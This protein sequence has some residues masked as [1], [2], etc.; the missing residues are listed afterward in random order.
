MKKVPSYNTRAYRFKKW[1]MK[2]WVLYKRRHERHQTGFM[3]KALE[4]HYYRPAFYRFVAA[5]VTNPHIL[6]EADINADSIV[7]DIGAYTGDWAKHLLDRYNPTVYAFEPNPN[8]FQVLERKKKHYPKLNPHPYGLGSRNEI[9]PMSMADLGSSFFEHDE[10]SPDTPW[11]EAEIKSVRDVWKALDFQDVDLVKINIEGAE[12][13]LLEQMIDSDL[14]SS[15]RIFMIQFHEWH[16][17][18]YKRRRRIRRALRKTHKLDWDYHFV[19][20]KW[21]RR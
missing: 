15:V 21:T 19:W 6:H 20:E 3:Q 7:I 13:E 16:P 17:G 4:L 9:L 5:S 12:Y 1:L 2:P 8:I 14:M 18:A 10:K 11:R